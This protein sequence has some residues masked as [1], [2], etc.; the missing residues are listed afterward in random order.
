MI[1]NPEAPEVR[2][3]DLV[4]TF[5]GQLVLRRLNLTVPARSV[6]TLVGASGAGK[7]TLL[8][9]V[10]GLLA[11]Y[12]G[13]VTIG[14]RDVWDSS[15]AELREI[16]RGISALLS[17]PTLFNGSTYASLT[18]REH[19]LAVLWEKHGE[20]VGPAREHGSNPYLKLWTP[21]LEG[22]RGRSI[23]GELIERANAV[24]ERFDL[25]DVAELR[26]DELAARVRRRA[27]LAATLTVDV[28]LYVLDD[29]DG[30]LD[31]TH[32]RAIIDTLRETQVRA[33]ATVLV[34]THDLALAEEISDRVMVLAAGRIVAEGAPGETLRGIEA[35]YEMEDDYRLNESSTPAPI[36]GQRPYSNAR[37][38]TRLA[39][40]LDLP[41][42]HADD[43]ARHWGFVLALALLAAVIALVTGWAAL[44]Y[45][46]WR[47]V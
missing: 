28:P 11:P 22:S 32:R 13:T 35:W 9:H 38:L 8:R 30:A 12:R 33:G 34:T 7:T 47:P 14:G 17:G 31:S 43:A 16:R 18:V 15:E 3:H 36:P 40:R 23:P 6:T 24:L 10:L 4:T 44:H 2:C 25:V 29:P 5:D 26:P 1:G 46:A 20:A 39:Q 27:A 21:G 41:D 37:P 42:P 19:L 45:S